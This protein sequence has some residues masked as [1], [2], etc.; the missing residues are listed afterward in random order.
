MKRLFL[1]LLN[2]PLAFVAVLATLA[3][4]DLGG[5]SWLDTVFA[6]AAAVGAAAARFVVDGPVTVHD[7]QNP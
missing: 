4:L 5:P 2:E 6:A 1:I 3:A 7:R